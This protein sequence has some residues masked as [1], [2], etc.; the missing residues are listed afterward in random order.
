MNKTNSIKLYSDVRCEHPINTIE[1]DNSMIIKLMDGSEEILPNTVGSGEVAVAT[2]YLR[3]ETKFRFGITAISFPDKRLKID[4]GN[5]WLLP[6]LPTKIII[7][8]KVPNE[9]TPEDVI[10]PSN[11]TI[12]GYYIYTP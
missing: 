11:I 1:W 7:S 5:K 10:K 2:A 6:G 4:I 9:V 12:E 8:F 3:N